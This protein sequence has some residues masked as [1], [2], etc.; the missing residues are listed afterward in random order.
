MDS[1]M[2]EPAMDP[3]PGV[4]PNFSD[5][6]GSSSIGYGVVIAS[7]I[8]STIAVLAR[9]VSS[10][11]TRKLVIEDFLMVAALGVFAGNQY[12]TYNLS[13]Y[14]G[15]WAHQWNIQNKFLP[16]FLYNSHLG[17][18]FY[19]PIAMCIKVAILVNWLRIFVPAGQRNYVYWTLHTLIWTNIVFYVITTITEIFRCSPRELIWNPFL[20]GGSCPIDVEDQNII[21]SV[22]NFL[23]DTTIL[24]MPQWVIWKLQMSTSRKWGLSLL[25][26]IGIGAWTF[27]VIRLVYF[28]K[29]LQS[30]DVVYQMS[31][32]ALWTIWEVTTGFLI[33]GI[34]AFPRAAKSL[35]MSDSIASFF[36]SWKGSNQLN[37]SRAGL[38]QWQWY[39]PKTRKRRGLWEI[40][41]LESHN[42]VSIRST[43]DTSNT[44]SQVRI[45]LGTREGDDPN[46]LQII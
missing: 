40:S 37:G 20:E 32:V 7:S 41:E 18:V 45:E 12:I 17:A 38:P 31:G 42:L 8:I 19:G 22:L 24:A 46:K 16:H 14:P 4:V 10:A 34:P 28:I 9:L 3:P 44:V 33:M 1:F 25:F 39:K 15:F 11:A 30:D 13:I 21:T 26:L 6:G 5:T 29:L 36:R 43:G 2:D 27:G 35:P 23:S